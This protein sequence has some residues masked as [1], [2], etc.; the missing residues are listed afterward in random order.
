MQAALLSLV[1]LILG[2]F[3]ICCSAEPVYDPESGLLTLGSVVTADR[4]I[5][6]RDVDI[7]LDSDGSYALLSATPA[8]AGVLYVD[9]LVSVYDGDTFKVNIHHLHPLL[10]QNI[11]IRTYGIDAPE[12]EGKCEQEIL[13][14]RQ[15]RDLAA[16]TLKNAKVIKLTELERDNY[17]RIGAIVYVDGVKFNDI[18]LKA[19]LVVPYDPH[20][21]MDWCR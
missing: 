16:A 21:R 18:M 19:G 4:E 15:A 9:E 10:G 6:F 5:V 20:N 1:I 17:F 2:T 3:P 11:R 13:L 14:A 8:E 12:I 7:R